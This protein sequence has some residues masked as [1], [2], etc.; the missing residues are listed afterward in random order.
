MPVVS[1]QGFGKW[2]GEKQGD[3][4]DNWHRT[5]I[6]PGLFR[7]LGR[8]PSGTRVLDI[9]CGNGYIARRLARGG[10]R[11]VGVDASREL[12]AYARAEEK[13]RPLGIVYHLADAARLPAW[14]KGS[15]DVAVANMSLIDIEDADGAI[16]ELAR[17]VRPGGRFVFSISH[18]CFDVDRQSTWSVE[19]RARKTLI[20][21][22]VADYRVLHSEEYLWN[23]KGGVI[24]QT[25]GYHRPLSWYAHVLHRYGW[26]ILDLD[27]PKPRR[28]YGSQ[29]VRKEWVEAIPLHLVVEARREFPR[30]SR[31]TSRMKGTTHRKGG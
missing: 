5:L 29:R 20:Y 6:D 4:G 11:V 10:A 19:T 18:P 25:T 30:A 31:K 21:R 12:I 16:R 28:G 13:V 17:V 27:E 14:E 9:G 22:K 3:T 26:T 24:A 1:L 23:L 15:F 8:L 7:L 2:Y